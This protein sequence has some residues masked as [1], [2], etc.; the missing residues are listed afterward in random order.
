MFIK[1]N[2]ADFLPL[3]FPA[4][5]KSCCSVS[6]S[7]AIATACNSLSDNF[8]LS[9]NHLSNSTNELFPMLSGVLRSRFALNQTYIS[10]KL[11]VSDLVFMFQKN[12]IIIL[13]VILSCR[14]VPVNLSIAL[15]ICVSFWV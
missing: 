4:F 5:H 7:L 12:L 9:P 14:S 11:F 1:L 3:L 8:S 6:V 15:C 2:N 10:S 13:F